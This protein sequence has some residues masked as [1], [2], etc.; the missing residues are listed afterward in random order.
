MN[1]KRILLALAVLLITANTVFSQTDYKWTKYYMEAGILGGDSYYLGDAN[2]TPFKYMLPTGGLFLKYKFNG[3]WEIKLQ[4]TLG[5]AGIGEFDGKMRKTSFTDLAFITEFNFFN[6]ASM[7]LEPGTSRV[8]PYIF[9]GLGLSS[10]N[11]VAAPIVP[12]GIG[13]KWYFANRLNLGMYWSTQKTLGNDK[14]DLIDNPLGIRTNLWLNNDW[15]S[16][17][18]VYL[19]INFWKICPACI[20]GSVKVKKRRR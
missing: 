3:H 10:F 9:G 2:E 1:H 15:Y 19:S 5:Q 7:R 12:F 11:Q 14:F 4:A 17:I 20:D 8:S 16:T 18:A 13:V 6:Y